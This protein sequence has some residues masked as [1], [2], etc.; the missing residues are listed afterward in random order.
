MSIE[1]T[2]HKIIGNI[3]QEFATCGRISAT[4]DIWTDASHSTYLGM[5]LH[6]LD[7]EFNLISRFVGLRKLS[8]RE[9]AICI[10]KETSALLELFDLSIS[11]IDFI[12]TD[13]AS[14]MICAFKQDV[15]CKKSFNLVNYTIFS[16]V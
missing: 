9:T 7:K 11:S 10:R 3:K 16:N 8:S 5:T 12:V 2:A 15:K 14:N 4:L 6:M 1:R 13:N